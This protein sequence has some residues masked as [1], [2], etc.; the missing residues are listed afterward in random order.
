MLEVRNAMSELTRAFRNRD[1]R[2]DRPQ[3][4][5]SVSLNRLMHL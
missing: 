2:N 3:V 5:A 1:V 4:R